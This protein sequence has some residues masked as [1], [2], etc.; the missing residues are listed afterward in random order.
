MKLAIRRTILLKFIKFLRWSKIA[1]KFAA[2]GATITG[3]LASLSGSATAGIA[4]SAAG[5]TTYAA[6]DLP[7]QGYERT[8]HVPPGR[9]QQSVNMQRTMGRVNKPG[10]QMKMNTS[11]LQT[12]QPP[13]RNASSMA[14][15]HLPRKK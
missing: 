7:A 14:V 5:A 1:A 6:T 9:T 4:L 3:A 11:L 8:K 13:A 2:V 10:K 12:K 15:T